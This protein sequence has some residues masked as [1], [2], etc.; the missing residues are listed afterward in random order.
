M[1]GNKYLTICFQGLKTAQMLKVASLL[2]L[3]N[4]VL[5]SPKFSKI[6]PSTRHHSFDL[7]FKL[8]IVAEAQA[9][10]NNREIARE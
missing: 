6:M 8:K 5:Q 4:T 10:N 3:V 7:N 9:V 2:H 1:T